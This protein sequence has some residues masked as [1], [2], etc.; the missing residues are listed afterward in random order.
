M[1]PLF[2][3]KAGKALHNKIHNLVHQR[4]ENH[5]GPVVLTEFLAKL[6][7][8]SAKKALTNGT[9]S[10]RRVIDLVM[11]MGSTCSQSTVIEGAKKIASAI[12]DLAEKG[13]ITGGNGA[14]QCY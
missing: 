14:S 1:R 3:V 5:G 7:H 9:I 12:N 11:F 10:Y 6:G 4:D 8:K 13:Y 2:T